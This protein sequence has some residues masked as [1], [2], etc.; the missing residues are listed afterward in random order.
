LI[1][2]SIRM[3]T[4]RK[5]DAQKQL[6]SIT[7]GPLTLGRLLQA[8]RQGEDWS[9]ADMGKKL[10]VTR[11]FISA[12]ENGKALS[13]MRAARYARKLGYSESQFVRLA[14]QD[15]LARAGLKYRVGL[16]EA[17]EASTP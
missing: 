7:G 2:Q 17:H 4:E 1:R 16:D 11:A 3:R 5:S 10:G 8:I 15:E 14:L 13:P 12:L 6:E 9:L